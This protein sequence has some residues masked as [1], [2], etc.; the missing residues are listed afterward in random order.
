MRI[1]LISLSKPSSPPLLGQEGR[2][3]HGGYVPKTGDW[4]SKEGGTWV[5]LVLGDLD[6]VLATSNLD[7]DI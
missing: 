7:L 1:Q 6:H 5:D 2:P 4:P 3:G